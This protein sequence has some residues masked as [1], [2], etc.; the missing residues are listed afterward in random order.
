MSNPASSE[1]PK[2]VVRPK[3]KSCKSKAI[4]NDFRNSFEHWGTPW[5]SS[6]PLSEQNRRLIVPIIKIAFGA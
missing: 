2:A 3:S 6:S 5:F 1:A 4:L